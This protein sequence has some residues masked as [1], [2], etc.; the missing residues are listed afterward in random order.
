V[1]YRQPSSSWSLQNALASV[2][3]SSSSSSTASASQ[4]NERRDKLKLE[5]YNIAREAAENIDKRRQYEMLGNMSRNAHVFKKTYATFTYDMLFRKGVTRIPIAPAGVI[6][7]DTKLTY[8]ELLSNYQNFLNTNDDMDLS[9]VASFGLIGVLAKTPRFEHEKFDHE[10]LM[11][12]RQF[13]VIRNTVHLIADTYEINHKK[14]VAVA[15]GIDLPTEFLT[16][17]GN[18]QVPDEIIEYLLF[19]KDS[20]NLLLVLFEI[21]VSTD[22]KRYLNAYYLLE[23]IIDIFEVAEEIAFMRYNNTIVGC[24]FIKG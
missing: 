4:I 13:D 19:E 16:L 21:V 18:I 14:N 8:T 15:E 20:L 24:T 2:S 6:R 22:L 23:K 1:L 10:N 17:Y 9:L 5:V 3:S 12:V 7:P 11:K